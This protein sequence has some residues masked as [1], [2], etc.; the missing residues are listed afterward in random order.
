[1]SILRSSFALRAVV[2]IIRRLVSCRVPHLANLLLRLVLKSVSLICD[3]TLIRVQRFDPLS[4]GARVV[5]TATAQN[6]S[7]W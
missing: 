1:M 3:V 7:I 2:F 6:T 5:V 4:L